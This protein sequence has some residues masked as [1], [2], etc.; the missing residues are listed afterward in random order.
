MMM[1]KQLTVGIGD[2]KF[3]REN[4]KIIT[5]ALGSCIGI[6]FYDPVLRLGA[7]LHIMLPERNNSSDL[8]VF[9]YADSGIQ[10][11]LR[12]LSAFGLV[13]RRTV[14]KIA[15]G[16]KMFDIKGSSDFGNIGQRNADM[17]KKIIAREQMVVQ[18][19]DTGGSY[20][21]TM[22]LDIANGDVV[23]RTVGRPEKHL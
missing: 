9:K 21:R 14:I 11:T 10:E 1:E 23:V 16:A 20:A 3:A 15:G 8:K 6:T 7:L 17:V 13:K 12:K 19:S 5:Y 22:L 4:G 18:S 2:M